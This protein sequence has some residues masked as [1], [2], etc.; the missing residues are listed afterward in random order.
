MGRI[1][2]ACS[3]ISRHDPARANPAAPHCAQC[4]DDRLY[5]RLP[6]FVAVGASGA[7]KSTVAADFTVSRRAPNAVCLDSDVLLIKGVSTRGWDEY[8]DIWV[9]VCVHIPQSGQ[10][11]PARGC[12]R[13]HGTGF[14]LTQI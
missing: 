10:G 8:R 11:Q 14:P 1:C 12:S 4:E 13:R 6:L 2:P 7:G 9:C 3:D 5:R